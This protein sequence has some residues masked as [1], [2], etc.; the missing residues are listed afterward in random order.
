MYGASSDGDRNLMPNHLLQWEAI[1]WAK[2]QGCRQYDLWGIP[3]EAGATPAAGEGE[4]ASE[5]SESGLEGVYRFK[6]GFGGTVVRTVGAWD[7]VYSRPLYWLYA[8]ALPWY[9]GRRR[10]AGRPAPL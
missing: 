2:G 10:V 8:T 7:H 4:A 9:R 1:Q 3:D 5:R 6:S